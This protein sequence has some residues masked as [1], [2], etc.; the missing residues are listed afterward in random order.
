MPNK[1]SR[2]AKIQDELR[3]KAKELLVERTVNVVIGY[4]PTETGSVGA[5]FYTNSAD[6]D[7]LLWNERCTTNLVV[8]LKRKEVQK[9]GKA[10]I[11]VKG[12]DSKALAVLEVEKQLNRDGIYVIGVVCEGVWDDP[13]SKTHSDAAK[14]AVCD[15][16]EPLH[17]DLVIGTLAEKIPPKSLDERYKKL[18]TI[19][20]MNTEERLAYWKKEFARCFKCYACRQVCPMCYCEVCVADKNRPTRFDTSATE[21]GNF[22]WHIVR[23]FHLA[24]RCVGCSNCRSACPVGID[25]DLLNLTL[26][27]AA[28]TQ[29]GFQAGLDREALP[30][31]GTFSPSDQ[32]EFIR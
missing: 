31:V 30:L 7:K 12:C 29:F 10:A 15:V 13:N 20:A 8:Y 19:L 28:E 22:A 23:A 11:V 27:K 32:E 24:G 2:N 18:E 21:K 5:V 6:C 4:G 14:C 17:C 3:Q 16:H 1:Q 26:A 25:L 9:L